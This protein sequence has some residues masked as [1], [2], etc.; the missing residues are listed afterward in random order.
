MGKNRR[1][2][3]KLTLDIE[4]PRIDSA[5]F[6]RAVDA[7]VD[8]IQEVS[9]EVEGGAQAVRWLMSVSGGSVHLSALPERKRPNARIGEITRAIRSGM[10]L[11]E[12]R[13]ERPKYFTDNA[14]SLTQRIPKISLI[15]ANSRISGVFR[16]LTGA[17]HL[18]GRAQGK[19][20]T[21]AAPR[22]S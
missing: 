11:I 9:R 6:K 19:N 20:R 14:L 15:F 5:K 16:Q 12:R 4:G 18:A 17:I 2:V 8:L 22:A 21:R 7:F 13:A 1:D 10:S 3:S